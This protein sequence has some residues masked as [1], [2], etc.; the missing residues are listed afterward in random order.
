MYAQHSQHA[1][2]QISLL[3]QQ[4][5]VTVTCTKN[6]CIG[7]KLVN[8]KHWNKC[9]L[10][11]GCTLNGIPAIVTYI[12]QMIEYSS[13][14]AS[15]L[16]LACPFMPG[17]STCT[18]D[19]MKTAMAN[20][21]RQPICKERYHFSG[22]LFSSRQC[23][24]LENKLHV[25]QVISRFLHQTFAPAVYAAGGAQWTALEQVDSCAL[26]CRSSFFSQIKQALLV[27]QSMLQAS[28]AVTPSSVVTDP[29][30]MLC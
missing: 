24:S 14:T 8:A 30:P 4:A 17:L 21:C 27:Q 5:K 18:A 22:L 23:G 9:K 10:L 12:C 6:R 25:T 26:E 15:F 11:L 20:T 2:M 28:A 1:E 7:A 19:L 29:T 3:A 13:S 16:T